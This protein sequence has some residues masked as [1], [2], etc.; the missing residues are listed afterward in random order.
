[1]AFLLHVTAVVTS[2]LA[3]FAERLDGFLPSE[4]RQA[5]SALLEEIRSAPL[6][7]A[8]DHALRAHTG[9]SSTV[10]RWLERQPHSAEI[11]TV[12]Q[13]TCPE[14]LFEHL[15]EDSWHSSDMPGSSSCSRRYWA[16]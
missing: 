4:H 6:F 2:A 3:S 8:V 1:M 13:L 11:A 10:G 7:S 5:V 9:T 12:L 15:T 16:P 14:A